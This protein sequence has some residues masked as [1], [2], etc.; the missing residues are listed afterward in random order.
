[1]YK[2]VL[3][4][5]AEGYEDIE[6]VTAIDVLTRVGIKVTICGLKVRPVRGAYGST[7]IGDTTIDKIEGEF[8]GLV[9]PGG[10]ECARALASEEKVVELV[11]NHHE[12]G[13][14]I[15]AICASSSL[16]LG[17][18]CGLLKDINATGDPELMDVLAKSGAIIC[19]ESVVR[20]GNIVT[21]MGPGGAMRFSLALVE[22]L[23]G[24]S[25]A[26]KLADKWCI[27]IGTAAL[28]RITS[29]V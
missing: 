6:A 16:L 10:L 7:I 24:K 22:Y 27:D 19:Q 1:M 29:A 21:G 9:F 11:K 5:L 20:D 14:L 17:E 13:K 25:S 23:I 3:I 28:S 12:K 18:K 4:T 15:A 2:T 26:N 8:D